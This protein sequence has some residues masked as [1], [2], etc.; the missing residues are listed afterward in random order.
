MFFVRNPDGEISGL[1]T[2]HKLDAPREEPPVPVEMTRLPNSTRNISN[3]P[4]IQCGRCSIMLEYRT[5]ADFVHCPRC[6]SYNPTSASGATGAT[7]GTFRMMCSNCSVTNI[8]PFGANLVRCGHCS[9]VND[10]SHIY[11]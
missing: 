1:C 9:T 7:G 2:D 10:I 5:G 6:N 3:N 11:R 4:R 8:L